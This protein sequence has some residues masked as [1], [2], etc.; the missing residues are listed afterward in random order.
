MLIACSENSEVQN[1][2]PDNLILTVEILD[3]EPTAIITAVADNA[4]EYHF[5]VGEAQMENPIINTVG[6]I[7]HT[8][9]A[10]G[11][12]VIE[13]RA[14]GESGRFVRKTKQIAIQT[15]GG[16][17]SVGDGYTSPT[18]YPGMQLRWNDE[19][20]GTALSTSNWTH[21]I[22]TGCPNICGW[23]NNELQYYRQE[24]TTVSG[25]VLTIEARNEN[26]QGSNYTSS[27]IISKGKQSFQYGRMDIR[28]LLPEGQGIWPALWMLGA[29]ISSVGW[30]RCGEI[31]I[32]EMIGGNGREN[33]THGTAHWDENGRV[34]DSG[35]FTLSEGS[36]SDEYHVFSIVWTDEL[37]SFLVND[38]EYHSFS[39][40]QSERAAFQKE[41]FFIMNIAVGGDWPGS[42]NSSTFFPTRMSVDY[43]R[44]FQFN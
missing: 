22:G 14:Y 8:Y 43:V 23:G 32:M 29:N 44:V 36:F 18:S 19:F 3:G 13:V 37:I 1:L 42:P 30:P 4:T 25:G 17:I 5:Y 12:Y 39:I 40:T 27:R 26:F 6:T 7:Q 16:P 10:F 38:Q 21:E 35:S 20:E 28:A 15:G 24:N 11:S 34:L 2:D 9:S 33:T 31:D 41:F